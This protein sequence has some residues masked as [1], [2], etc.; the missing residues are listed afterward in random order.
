[1]TFTFNIVYFIKKNIFKCLNT[2]FKEQV[3]FTNIE[4][5]F[6]IFYG[7]DYQ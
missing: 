7:F 1:M 2:S 6:K 3:N 4:S 5:Y